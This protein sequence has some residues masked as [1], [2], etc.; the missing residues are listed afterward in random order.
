MLNLPQVLLDRSR[1]TISE[2]GLRFLEQR[3]WVES[4]EVEPVFTQN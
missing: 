3:H 4:K 2:R 1:V